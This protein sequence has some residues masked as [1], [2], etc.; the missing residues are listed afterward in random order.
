[1]LLVPRGLPTY[2]WKNLSPA[3]DDGPVISNPNG[4]PENIV[5]LQRAE[6]IVG[7]LD[8]GIAVL[9]PDFQIRWANRPFRSWCATEP[10]SKTFF[11]ALGL[12]DSA[13]PVDR[14]FETVLHSGHAVCFRLLKNELVLDVTVSPVWEAGRVVD[15]VA[16][17]DDVTSAVQRQQKLNALYDAG[18]VLDALDPDQLAEMNVACRVELLKQN[19][20]RYVHDLLKYN[21]V[22]VRLLDRQTGRLDPLMEEGMTEQAAARALF[23]REEG[24][25][26]TGYVAATG[27]PYLCSDTAT[28]PHFIEGSVGAKSSMTVPIVYQDEVIGTFNVE[29]P[30]PNSF[31]PEDLQFTELFARELGRS[32]HTL[33]LLN[34]QER[35]AATG[36]IETVNRDI[37]LPADELLSLASGLIAATADRPDLAEGL[38]KI[39]ATA[40]K[41]KLAVRRVGV[42]ITGVSP[43][44]V[45]P[46]LDGMRVLVVD[47]DE[48][49]RRSAHAILERRGCVVEAATNP[50]DGIAMARAGTYDAV[51]V[52]VKHK[53]M[54]GTAAYRALVAAVPL[55]RVI[56]TQGFE[57]DGGHT[58]VNARQDGYWLPV[59]F[60]PF[61]E[62]MLVKALTCSAPA[63]PSKALPSVAAAS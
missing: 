3:T 59:L 37:A 35:C 21:V 42:E 8:K 51:L 7:A 19:V 25:G 32:L 52:A 20:R 54:G 48:R 24:N 61:Q 15:M 34:A 46:A 55:G 4:D 1:M 40:R 26:V 16:L 57:Y 14:P 45:D 62:P 17:C 18:Q 63:A 33:N 29:S 5:R 49:I 47:A 30:R 43:V 50:V 44:S 27:K 2:N 36:V 6:Q 60:K 9:G 12:P 28:D 13:N 23:A 56:L 53:E 11:G 39:L 38:Q 22:E 58:V 10:V 41:I 31:G